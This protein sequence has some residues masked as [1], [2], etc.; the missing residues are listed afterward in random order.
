MLNCCCII[1]C[2]EMIQ[3]N[4]QKKHN[5]FDENMCCCVFSILCCGVICMNIYR[6][7]ERAEQKMQ[8]MRYDNQQYLRYIKTLKRM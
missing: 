6:E 4:T 5:D 8:K 7:N 1:S 2:L 3:E